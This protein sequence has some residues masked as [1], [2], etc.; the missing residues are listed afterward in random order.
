MNEESSEKALQR[1]KRIVDNMRAKLD[2]DAINQFEIDS[3]SQLDEITL[4]IWYD[5]DGDGPTVSVPPFCAEEFRQLILPFLRKY[6]V[7]E[8]EI[9]LKAC[10]VLKPFEKPEPFK[11]TG[12][13]SIPIINPRSADSE[14]ADR[15]EVAHDDSI[16][17]GNALPDDLMSTSQD[18][19]KTFPMSELPPVEWWIVRNEET[20]K[21]KLV[22]S[23]SRP[24]TGCVV[25]GYSS[26]ERA[27]QDLQAMK[28]GCKNKE[29][30]R[31]E[32]SSH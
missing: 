6:Q 23:K 31:N 17:T 20:G 21:P 14:Q 5:D 28:P 9:I 18:K 30:E 26:E 16:V 8:A 27:K 1:L 32:A 11:I 24:T 19:A 12:Y 4:M 3:L 2:P 29:D 10:E 7:I 25:S 15:A 22:K 13:E